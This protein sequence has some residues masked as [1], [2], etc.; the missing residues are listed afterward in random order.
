MRPIIIQVSDACFAGCAL[1]VEDS[2]GLIVINTDEK[3]LPKK[4]WTTQKTWFEQILKQLDR[5]DDI[6]S[7]VVLTREAHVQDFFVQLFNG[8][9]KAKI[10]ISKDTN[11]A[12]PRPFHYLVSRENKLNLIVETSA[13]TIELVNP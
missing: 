9:K 8:A 5:D 13:G 6:K 11:K 12:S 10:F 2:I 7:V 3:T 1:L 4:V